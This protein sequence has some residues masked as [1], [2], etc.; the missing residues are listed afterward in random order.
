MK[1]ESTVPLVHIGLGVTNVT[2]GATPT[3]L[4]GVAAVTTPKVKLSYG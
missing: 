4:A 3:M 1:P 2:S